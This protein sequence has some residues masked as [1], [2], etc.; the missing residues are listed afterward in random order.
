MEAAILY[1]EMECSKLAMRLWKSYRIGVSVIPGTIQCVSQLYLASSHHCRERVQ[2]TVFS[3]VK[4]DL[5]VDWVFVGGHDGQRPKKCRVEMME[6]T[7]NQYS[8]S[9]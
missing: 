8:V 4:D 5:P 1:L 3:N 9:K 6:I 2:I 7:E